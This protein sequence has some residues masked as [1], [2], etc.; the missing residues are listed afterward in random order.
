MSFVILNI[1]F[2]RL[3]SGTTNVIDGAKL[4]VKNIVLNQWKLITILKSYLSKYTK[5]K[6]FENAINKEFLIFLRKI[7]P[8]VYGSDLFRYFV[9][10][11]SNVKQ[12]KDIH[13]QAS[14]LPSVLNGLKIKKDK[15]PNEVITPKW[16]VVA[17]STISKVND[18]LNS[19][20][21]P[22]I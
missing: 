10:E 11:A 13:E 12:S 8:K 5:D 15:V 22:S 18:I 21:I 7:D 3:N 9:S 16:K 4:Q 2:R 14:V 17:K 19:Y 20:V 6:T 1:L